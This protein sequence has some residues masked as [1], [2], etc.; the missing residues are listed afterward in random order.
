MDDIIER[1]SGEHWWL[2]VDGAE[3]ANEI[4]RLRAEVT[5]IRNTA[6]INLKVAQERGADNERLRAALEPFQRNVEAVSLF[7]ALGHIGRD[8][9]WNARH[10]Y[11]QKER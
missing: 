2:N 3:A 7:A 9:L 5:T 1:L 6:K 11:E 4:K 8:E 10:A